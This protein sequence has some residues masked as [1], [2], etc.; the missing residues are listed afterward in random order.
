MDD[1]GAVLILPLL[2]RGLTNFPAYKRRVGWR[3]D[4]W[5]ERGDACPSSAGS[6]MWETGSALKTGGIGN[7]CER[8]YEK[9]HY[10]RGGRPLRVNSAAKV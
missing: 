4:P 7:H 2:H 1:A 8:P 9:A 10:P 6:R 5:T 3:L